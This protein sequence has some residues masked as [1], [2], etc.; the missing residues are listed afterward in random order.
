VVKLLAAVDVRELD[1]ARVDVDSDLELV[2]L[3]LCAT[4]VPRPKARE[5]Q[6]VVYT[7]RPA[8]ALNDAQKRERARKANGKK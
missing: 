3:L 8:I 5:S 6:N 4:T 7:A 1:D 2:L